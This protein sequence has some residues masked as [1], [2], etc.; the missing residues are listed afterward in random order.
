MAN[1]VVDPKLDIGKV[2]DRV[3]GKFLLYLL[4]RTRLED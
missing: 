3:D 1:E 2:Y 4:R